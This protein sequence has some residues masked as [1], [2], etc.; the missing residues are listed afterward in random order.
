MHLRLDIHYE[1]RDLFFYVT[2]KTLIILRSFDNPTEP[3]VFLMCV[4]MYEERRFIKLLHDFDLI[5][6]MAMKM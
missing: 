6:T 3:V 4:M 5:P 2:S 1:I